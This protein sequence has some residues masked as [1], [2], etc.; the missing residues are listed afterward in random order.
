MLFRSPVKSGGLGIRNK[1]RLS[2]AAYIGGVEQAVSSFTGP[3]GVCHQLENL[4]GN[5]EEIGWQ[6][7]WK[8][9]ID[10][11][12]RT[13]Q[14]FRM[15]WET[16]QKEAIQCCEYLGMDISGPLSISTEGA[17]EGSVDGSTRKLAI[18][19]L[20]ELRGAVAQHAM[21]LKDQSSRQVKSFQNR[22]KLTTAWLQCLPGPEGMGNSTFSEAMALV[23]CLPSPACKNRVGQKIKNKTVDIYGDNIM[24]AFLPGDSWRTK[25]DC[26]K[27]QISSLCKW[28]RLG[29]DTEVFGLF[30]H[31]IPAQAL[32]RN[33]SGRKRQG[34][35]PD[36]RL[37]F[38]S[39]MRG[40]DFRLAELK[41]LNCCLTRYPSSAGG[42]VKG[43]D[44]RANLLQNEYTRKV[45]K[46]ED[47]ITEEKPGP[48][49]RR[50]IEYGSIM[51][52]VF[53]A[54]GEG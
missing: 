45:I 48:L 31:L 40:L 49:E 18:D 53:G 12:C 20:E 52:L 7:K 21:S 24:S 35:V 8:A 10:S 32:T 30:S 28:A 15:A 50:L 26:V 5:M 47:T 33:E 9:M 4:I 11:G 39:P 19:Q 42:N 41:M 14:E 54:F 38:P 27:M 2:Y 6:E 1:E 51:G 13:G 46:I 43:V 36:F 22:D 29:S 16:L 44:R 3:D 25:H 23:L 34:L 37:S 17:G